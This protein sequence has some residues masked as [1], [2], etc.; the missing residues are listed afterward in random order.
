[1]EQNEPFAPVL[2]ISL[3]LV[4]SDSSAGTRAAPSLQ[5]K[6]RGGC[7]WTANKASKCKGL[8]DLRL[9]PNPLPPATQP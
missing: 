2:K 5:G 6:L 7:V 1:M 3:Q 8:P 4:A 9:Q